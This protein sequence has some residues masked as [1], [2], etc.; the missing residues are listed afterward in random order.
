MLCSTVK[1]R[2]D[3]INFDDRFGQ[4]EIETV[5]MR[6]IYGL[7]NRVGAIVLV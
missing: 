3:H 4:S 7:S 6:G 1:V 5:F 2:E